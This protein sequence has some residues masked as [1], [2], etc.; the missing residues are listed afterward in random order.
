[1]NLCI[2]LLTKWM[3]TC[4]VRVND[5]PSKYRTVIYSQYVIGWDHFLLCNI[6]Q[7][8]L[9]LYDETWQQSK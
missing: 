6:S 3:G 4:M 9:K 2:I 5:F 1:M 8:W 7:G